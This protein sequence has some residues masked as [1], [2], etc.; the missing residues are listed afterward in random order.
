MA[1]GP[2]LL[3]KVDPGKR[4]S[5]CKC[6]LTATQLAHPTLPGYAFFLHRFPLATAQQRSAARAGRC[7]LRLG[8]TQAIRLMRKPFF[9]LCSCIRERK[10]RCRLSALERNKRCKTKSVCYSTTF[11]SHF[12]SEKRRQNL[13]GYNSIKLMKNSVI[14]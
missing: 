6:F 10:R 12:F 5:L 8:R 11:F 4:T 14:L 3:Q 9:P 13:I 1:S 7:S 2:M